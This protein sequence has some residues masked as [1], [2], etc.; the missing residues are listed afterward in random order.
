MF[1]YKDWG[2]I[3]QRL[4]QIIFPQKKTTKYPRDYLQPRRSRQ[5][6]HMFVIHLHHPKSSTSPPTHV[7]TS[8]HQPI[9]RL[10]ILTY[11]CIVL[12][13]WHANFK[14]PHTVCSFL[15]L[16]ICLLNRL[17]HR[18]QL[19]GSTNKPIDRKVSA[20]SYTTSFT[21]GWTWFADKIIYQITC[22]TCKAMLFYFKEVQ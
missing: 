13:L 14:P 17:T 19:Y 21:V 16:A 4:N 15:L 7:A 9:H 5:L 11:F 6:T 20:F 3:S 18:Q 22:F 10:D 8:I 1:S 12:G 2:F